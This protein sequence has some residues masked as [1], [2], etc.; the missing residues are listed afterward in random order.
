VDQH[1]LKV[2]IERRWNMNTCFKRGLVLAVITSLSAISVNSAMAQSYL[3]G[4]AKARGDYGQMSRNSVSPMYWTTAPIQ[5]R[6]FSYEAAPSNSDSGKTAATKQPTAPQGSVARKDTKNDRTY[7][8][9]P[10]PA[11]GTMRSRSGTAPLWALPKSDS[12]K[13]GGQ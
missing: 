3:D 6:S 12:R 8:Y 4:S 5:Q 9:E 7:S 10:G 13:F 1:F 11:T 2:P